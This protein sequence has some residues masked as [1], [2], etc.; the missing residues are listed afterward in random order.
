MQTVVHIDG[1]VV[2]RLHPGRAERPGAALRQAHREAVEVSFR[3]WTFLVDTLA[4]W[5]GASVRTLLGR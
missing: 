2:S 5:A 4:R 3:Q 1:D